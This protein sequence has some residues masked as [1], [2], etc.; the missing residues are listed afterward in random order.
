MV[1][2]NVR[3]GQIKDADVSL[4]VDVTGTL[5]VGNG[6]TGAVTL[7]GL[8]VGNGTSAFTTISAPSGTVVGT[9]DTQ[10]QTNKTLSDTFIGES[11]D[12]Q[13][14][15]RDTIL[16][17]AN[18]FTIMDVIEIAS[19]TSLEIPSTSTLEILTYPRNRLWGRS[20]VPG[21]SITINTDVYDQYLLSSLGAAVA[22][23]LTGNG[24]SILVGFKDDGTARA[25]T[26][27]NAQSSGVATLL[28][29][30]VINKTH[31]VGLRHDGSTWTCL[32]VDATGY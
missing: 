28:S 18:D 15:Q 20:T 29:T 16:L 17:A 9:T 5:P 27:P 22:V 13:K 31:W 24:R 8:L 19:T 4:T 2:T 23:T 21:A 10:T 14:T 6:G 1:A 25:V 30:T 32:A 7:T 11:F 12:T 3:G 26:W